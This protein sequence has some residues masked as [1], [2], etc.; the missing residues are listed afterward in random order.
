MPVCVYVHVICLCVV[1]AVLVEQ[2]FLCGF[3]HTAL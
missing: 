3:E 2:C 1:L